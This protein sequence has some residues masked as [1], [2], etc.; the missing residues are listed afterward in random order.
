MI[1]R[2]EGSSRITHWESAQVQLQEV[3]WGE[4]AAQETGEG[5]NSSAA[6]N[7]SVEGATE[8]RHWSGAAVSGWRS[9]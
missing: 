4:L 5:D 9:R 3:G 1:V 7:W 8:M 6:G 2:R